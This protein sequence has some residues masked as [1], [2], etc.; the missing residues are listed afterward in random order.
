[1]GAYMEG[2]V[3]S[4]EIRMKRK[5]IKLTMTTLLFVLVFACSIT[6]VFAG[7]KNGWNKAQTKYFK[8]GKAVTGLVTIDSDRYFFDKKTKLKAQEE[9][10]KISGKTYYFDKDGKMI[11]GKQEVNNYICNFNEKTGALISRKK[12][13]RPIYTGNGWYDIVIG[14]MVNKAGLKSSMSDEKIV[15]KTYLYVTKNFQYSKDLIKAGKKAKR[16][17]QTPS[18]EAQKE[19]EKNVK[20]LAEN[21]SIRVDNS[22]CFLLES[23]DLSSLF[24]G[25]DEGTEKTEEPEIVGYMIKEDWLFHTGVC[26][27]FSAIFT[28]MLKRM[29]VK[30]GKAGGVAYGFSHAWSWAYVNGVKYY[31]DPGNSIH[32]YRDNKKKVSYTL[33]KMT[34]EDL[35]KHH[36]ISTEW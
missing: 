8:K 16:Y 1:M 2:G 17:H 13:R 4:L 32:M 34:R 30:A 10:V 33:Y 31:Y 23:I 3:Y 22:H 24:G 28:L 18:D 26:D 27:D 21:G 6:T 29:G 7:N 19:M 20:T 14:E 36:K 35:K 25:E 5:P 15:K 9:F 12:D 11:Y